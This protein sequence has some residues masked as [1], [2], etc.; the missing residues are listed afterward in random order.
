[1]PPAHILLTSPWAAVGT[2]TV[3]RG[4]LEN[5]SGSDIC[6]YVLIL[7]R[8]KKQCLSATGMS[9]FPPNML[10]R[11]GIT[12]QFG[13]CTAPDTAVSWSMAQQGL[14]PCLSAHLLLVLGNLSQGWAGPVKSG[15]SPGAPE[16][17]G[18]KESRANRKNIIVLVAALPY[19][20]HTPAGS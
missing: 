16:S 5:I 19:V 14:D 1:M 6:W 13:G 9:G 20:A 12:P 11:L 10:V 8:S 18:K 15:A 4:T 7:L 17:W 2:C 3:D